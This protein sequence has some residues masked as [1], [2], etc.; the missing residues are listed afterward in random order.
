MHGVFRFDKQHRRSLGSVE[1]YWSIGFALN[2]V[3]LMES[4]VCSVV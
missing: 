1:Q 3:V 4:T 2:W